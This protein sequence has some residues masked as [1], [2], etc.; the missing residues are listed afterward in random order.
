MSESFSLTSHVP[1]WLWL[2]SLAAL[3][4]WVVFWRRSLVR[5]SR[6]RGLLSILLRILLLAAVLSCLTGPEAAVDSS[7]PVVLAKAAPTR[8]ATV[9]PIV[10]L[11]G[12]DHIRAGEPFTLDLL[13]NSGSSGT[14][15]VELTR[16][17]QPVPQEKM[18]LVAGENHRSVPFI[19]EKPARVVYEVGVS[20]DG[21]IRVRARTKCAGRL[22]DLR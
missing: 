10:Q 11:N 8:A 14:A 4:I 20:G 2:A 17:S 6:G 9:L 22:P 3:P 15:N 18:T 16:D 7:L 21:L 13:V 5:L 1:L 12:P 19:V